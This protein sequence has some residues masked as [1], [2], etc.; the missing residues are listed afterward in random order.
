LQ[1]RAEILGLYVNAIA[2]APRGAHP[3]SCYPDYS[4]ASEEILNYIE[5]CAAGRFDEYLEEFIK[6]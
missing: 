6:G 3:T 1:G 2:E 5:A 4:L